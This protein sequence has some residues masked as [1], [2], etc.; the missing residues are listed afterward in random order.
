MNTTDRPLDSNRGEPIAFDERTRRVLELRKQIREGT[1]RPAART[2][3]RAILQEWF[4]LGLELEREAGRPV[5]ETATERRQ[6][7][8]RFIVEPGVGPAEEAGSARTA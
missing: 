4:Q 5:V 2:I 7:A 6:A 1:Y 3:A 8:A